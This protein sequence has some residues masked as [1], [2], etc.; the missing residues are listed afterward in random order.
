MQSTLID[1]RVRPAGRPVWERKTRGRGW[2]APVAAP[3]V[4]VALT[5]V[6]RFL[7]DPILGDR[8]PFLLFLAPALLSSWRYGWK[9]GMLALALGLAAVLSL[10]IPLRWNRFW[11]G[12]ADQFALAVFVVVGVIS[13][14]M[15]ES[16]SRSM[17]RRDIQAAMLQAEIAEH[18]R[19]QEQ[20]RLATDQ[21]ERRVEQSTVE[22]SLATGQLQDEGAARRAAETRERRL[23]AIVASSEDAIVGKDLDDLITDWNTGAE[24]LFGYTSAETI[25]RPVTMLIPPDRREE[26]ARVTKRVCRGEEVLAYESVRLRKDG[27]EVPVS[28]RMSP[29]REN[30]R[31]VG[32]ASISRDLT[33]ARQLE[34]QLRQA[35]KMEAVGQLAGG[36]AHDFNNILTVINGYSEMLLGEQEPDSPGYQM[37]EQISEAGRRAASLTSQLLAFSRKQVL[38]PKVVDLNDTV[39]TSE[40]MLRRLIGEDVRLTT[41]LATR[42]GHVKVDPGQ[43]EQVIMNL[44]VNARDAMLDGGRVTIETADVNVDEEH[45]KTRAEIWPGRYALLSVSDTGTGMDEETKAR[46]FEPFFTTKEV[47]KGTGLGLAMV[48]GIIKQS[49]GHIVVDSEP[50]RGT[51]FNI[52]LPAVEGLRATG[53]SHAGADVPRGAETILLVEDEEAVRRLAKM[54][55]RNAGYTVLEA[56]HGGEAV[57]LAEAHKGPIHLLVSDV[58]MPE[59]G[60]R[61]LAERLS[62]SRPGLKVLFVSGYTDDAVVRHGIVESEMFFLHK[63]FSPAGLSGKVR[64]AL[65]DKGG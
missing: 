15:A 53:K 40:K 59:M 50:G 25:G 47:G 5:I 13:V 30:G 52:Y 19:T 11:T 57:R 45:A 16:L 33:N 46:I 3:V 51:T 43:M 48:H 28:V 61:L 55:L 32:L 6:I 36:V 44:A 4:L 35:Q 8:Y 63:P 29:I 18:E 27:V 31:I 26:A 56:S 14:V 21:L 39:R 65:D 49:G 20:L 34:A 17:R 23:A 64:E 60:G 24:H 1:I 62:A 42:L 7:L 41:T 54:A 37:L 12:F 9:S 38:Q 10:F 58:V 2:L 22:L